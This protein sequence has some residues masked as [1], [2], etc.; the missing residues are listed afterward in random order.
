MLRQIQTQKQVQKLLPKIVLNQNLLAIPAIA[1]DNLVK[2]E[3]EQNPLLEE[4]PESESEPTDDALLNEEKDQPDEDLIRDNPSPAETTGIILAS[5][6]D[7]SSMS[8]VTS[9]KKDEYDWDEYFENEA[10]EYK[11][12]DAGEA[13]PFD[14]GN[15]S[16]PGSKMHESLILQI[17]LSDLPRK[18]VFVAEEIICSLNEDGFFTDEPGD[19]VL[20]LNAKKKGTEF[21]SEKF[22]IEDFNS[23]LEFIHK[24]VDPPGIGARS[25]KES[26]KIQIERGKYESNLKSL[27]IEAISDHF[28]DIKNR[29]FERLEKELNA[30]PEEMKSV[31]ELLHGLNPKPGY[32]DDFDLE[33]YIVPDLIV[34]SRDGSYDIFLNEKFTPSLRVNRAYKDM[35]VNNKK[36]LDKDTKT[37]LLNNFNKAKWFIDA[38]NSRRDTM[39]KIMEAIIKRQRHFFDSNGE[40]LKPLLEKEI[41]E[42]I[43]MDTSTV[44]RAVKNKYVQTDFG[45]YEL[46]SFFNGTMLTSNGEDISNTEIKVKLKELIDHENKLHPLTDLEL[47][48]E[49]EKIGLRVARRTVAKYREALDYPIAKLRREI[50]N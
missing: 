37:Y 23:A 32:E 40:N 16:D 50:G 1:L 2:R 7:D 27:A 19:I 38:I 45:I 39:I 5:E 6:D 34:K 13:T 30:T 10:E 47:S 42:D 48:S 21:E 18:I 8:S 28:Q 33:N 25:L 46:R 43:K 22:T 4:G 15:I 36:D 12:Y 29:R 17:H 31:F 24:E 9:D 26:L 14:Y 41:A 49:L 3:L 44:S 20:D 35:Y 11:S